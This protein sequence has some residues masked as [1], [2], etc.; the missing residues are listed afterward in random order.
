MEKVDKLIRKIQIVYTEIAR[1]LIDARF[2]IVPGGIF[3]KAAKNV[4]TAIE[5]KYGAVTEER[6]VDFCIR[7][8]YMN[9]KDMAHMSI[10]RLLNKRYVAMLGNAKPGMMHYE[11]E[12]LDQG[13]LSRDKLIHLIIDRS[14]HP[15]AGYISMPA[16][17]S[18]KQRMHNTDAGFALCMV[19]T[20]GWSPTSP[21]CTSCT[22]T[23]RCREFTRIKYPELYRLR[24]EY[25][26]TS[27][28]QSAD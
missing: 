28:Q 4:L 1:A 20:L 21:S 17:E 19:S 15:L 24:E 25:E 12:W 6:L 18:T 5:S 11:N 26:R 8:M 7:S 3:N 16:E 22:N 13:G 23:Q 2:K 14:V 27:Q 9:Y 10:H